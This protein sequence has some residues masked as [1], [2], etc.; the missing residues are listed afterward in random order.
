MSDKFETEFSSLSVI[1][2]LQVDNFSRH[3]SQILSKAL[4][5]LID[6]FA[7]ATGCE[8]TSLVFGM[9]TCSLFLHRDSIEYDQWGAA[10]DDNGDRL[11]GIEP[12]YEALEDALECFNNLVHYSDPFLANYEGKYAPA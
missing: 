11:P 10:T 12:L 3:T 6:E 9:G 8:V 7:K 4:D 2:D 5:D 1:W